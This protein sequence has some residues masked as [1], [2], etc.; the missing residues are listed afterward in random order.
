MTDEH[1]NLE[2][3]LKTIEYRI[4]KI[5][6]KKQKCKLTYDILDSEKIIKYKLI[7]LKETQRQMKIWI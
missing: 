7:S 6:I 3:Y 4:K 5:L 2:K 1:F